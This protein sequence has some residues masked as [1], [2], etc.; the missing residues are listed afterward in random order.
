[1]MGE[2]N[3]ATLTTAERDKL[4][5]SDFVLPDERAFPITDAASVADA[6]ASWGRYKGKATFA[7]FKE[8]L[9]ALAKRKGPDFEAQLP[10]KWKP[11]SATKADMSL[12][13]LRQEVC[14]ELGELMN[15]QPPFGPIYDWWVVDT[16]LDHAIVALGDDFWYVPFSVDASGEVVIAPRTEWFEVHKEWV[17]SPPEPDEGAAMAMKVGARHSVK[18][19]EGIQSIHDAAV[20]LGAECK[21]APVVKDE[22]KSAPS[23]AVKALGGDRVGA[24]AIL[25][26][27]KNEFDLSD[28]KDYFTKSTAYWLDAWDRRPILYHHA[29]DPDTKDIPV[30]GT[31]TKSV[32]TDDVGVWL[33]GQL[34][35]SHKYH[36]AIQEL[37]KAGKLFISSDSAPHLVTRKSVGGGVHEVT[38]WP[39]LAASLTV[40]PCEYRL[41][42]V[43]LKAL[44][45]AYQAAGIPFPELVDNPAP[46][47]EAKA[48]DPT[49]RESILAELLKLAI[50]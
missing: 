10:K 31:W 3:K 41:P 42:P 30:V 14:C 48:T 47:R 16:Y 28:T 33:E 2:E 50:D 43:E 36:S 8:N 40:S 39:L 15:G 9:T 37:L 45:D 7:Q 35:A 12:D 22:P 11:K 34:D 23:H 21:A 18:D 27:S 32:A 38:R 4:K 17:V 20:A 13:E 24:Y 49:E 5:D 25:Y 6:V 26:G 1:M 44:R 46:G 29:Q 19:Q